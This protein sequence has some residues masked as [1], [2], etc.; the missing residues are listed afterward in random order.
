MITAS[1]LAVWFGATFGVT[2][3]ARELSGKVLG[4]PFSFWVAAQ[5]AS[6]VCLVLVVLYARLM[7]R[8]DDANGAGDADD[9]EGRLT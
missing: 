9:V 5:G 6:L 7:G 2:Y 1:L 4:W 3:F 8:V